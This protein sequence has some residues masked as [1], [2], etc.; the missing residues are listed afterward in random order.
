MS[1]Q[2]SKLVEVVRTI[3]APLGGVTESQLLRFLW[4]LAEDTTEECMGGLKFVLRDAQSLQLSITV[5]A[6]GEQ[7]TKESSISTTQPG[8][9]SPTSLSLE[10]SSPSPSDQSD[11]LKNQMDIAAEAWRSEKQAPAS[12]T[13]HTFE[14][15]LLGNCS[16]CN[17]PLS[18]FQHTKI[19]VLDGALFQAEQD[20]ALD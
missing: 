11:E 12:Q 7:Q 13:R 20:P 4:S 19:G 3:P 18:A 14:G 17:M 16:K 8:T 5:S 1:D 6:I 15:W 10:D 9:S 2:I